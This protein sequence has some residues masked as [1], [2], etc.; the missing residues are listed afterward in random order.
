MQVFLEQMF[1]EMA[2]LDGKGMGALHLFPMY[3][4]IQLLIH[5]FFSILINVSKCVLSSVSCFSQLVH[6]KEEAVGTFNL[7]PIG[8][9]HR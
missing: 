6:T 7:K 5:I 1:Q 3:F 9:K 8:Q 2:H 4:F